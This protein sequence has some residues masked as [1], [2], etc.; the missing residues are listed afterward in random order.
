M[1]KIVLAL[2]LVLLAGCATGP[3]IDRSY[4]SG[5]QRDRVRFLVI[6]FTHANFERT[7]RIVTGEDVSYHYVV[8]DDP[9]TIYQLVD[10]ERSSFHAGVSSWRGVTQLN[11]ASI[12]VSLVNGGPGETDG[13]DNPAGWAPYSEAQLEVAIDLIKDIVSRHKIKPEFVVGHS[14]IAPQRKVDPGPLFPWKRLAE[15]G[16]AKWFEP[17]KVAER[18]PG[19]ERA[20]PEVEW[21]QVML[22]RYGYEVPIHG[23]LDR[24]TKNVLRVFQMHYRPARFDGLPDAETAAILDALVN[25]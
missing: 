11:D 10:E 18:L 22:R 7:M 5:A 9:P 24:A 15:A 17:A 13:G 8:R 21:F 12:G 4:G 19:Y 3:V 2:A 1:K 16:L 14:D 6:H 23:D 25:P 20:L